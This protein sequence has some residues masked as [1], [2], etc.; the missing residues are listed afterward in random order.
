MKKITLISI[1]I[2]IAFISAFITSCTDSIAQTNG[3][4]ALKERSAELAKA[5]EWEKTKEKVA[6]LTQ[7]IAKDP[8]DVKLK[9]QLATI[10]M[11]EARVTGDSYYHQASIEVLDQVLKTD[12]NNFE[13]NTYKASVAM[14]L[15]QFGEAKKLAEKAMQINPNNAYIY[16]VLV[17]INVEQ[18]DYATAIAMSDKMQALKPSLEAYSRASYLREINGDYKGAIDAMELA[19]KAGLAGS[20]SA[21]WSRVTLG[22]LYVA[23]GRLAEAETTYQN[24][25]AVRPNFPN[26]IMGLAKVA[27]AKK[28]YA[29]AIEYT[30]TAI[31]T[32]SEASFVAYLGQLYAL[33]GDAAKAAEVQNDVVRLLL[34]AEKE[35]NS[36]TILMKHNANRELANAYL[37]LK[38]YKKA[39][40]YAAID[41][42]LRPENIDANELMA[43]TTYL[44]GDAKA[45]LP[46]AE[47]MLRTK[48]MNA[49]KLTKAGLIITKSG[50]ATRGAALVAQAKT[51][52]S[53]VEVLPN[54]VQVLPN[55]VRK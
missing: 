29:K 33:S 16:G 47:K 50:D 5:N 41:L 23:T 17:D 3:L 10:F 34:A 46:Y 54:A 55:A 32:V 12:P 1:S 2:T 40:E 15:H 31:K 11:S 37:D 24:T 52:N 25:L 38:D 45:A 6:E 8:T 42:K 53:Y 18:G 44:N 22:D 14:S 20:E 26:A 13:A 43:W 4:P 27:H 7:K 19:V 49:E 36:S 48:S 35:Q 28:D 39:M 9:L 21:E 51:V 30:K